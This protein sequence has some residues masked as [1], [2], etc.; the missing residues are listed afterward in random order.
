[1]KKTRVMAFGTFD[2]LHAGHE[3]YL[4]SASELGDELIVVVSRDRTT[5]S[6]K[7]AKPEHPEKKRLKAVQAL[8]YVTKAILGNP[9]DKYQ[10]IRKWRPD[11]IALGYDQLVFTQQLPKLL[12]DMKSSAQIVR[13][14]S[15]QPTLY[16]SSLIKQRRDEG[17]K[18]L[19]DEVAAETET[20]T[21]LPSEVPVTAAEADILSSLPH[22]PSPLAPAQ[23]G[24]R[25]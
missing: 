16:K 2:I 23:S 12:I 3:N 10:V 5:K 14:P 21:I 9:E 4:K 20:D 1:M 19:P 6:L 22:A 13:L 7:G 15:Y 11:T 17:L 8:P 24:A 18:L 25:A